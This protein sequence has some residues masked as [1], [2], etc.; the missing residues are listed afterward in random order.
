[1]RVVCEK[2]VG[3][4]CLTSVGLLSSQRLGGMCGVDGGDTQTH[5][6]A[7]LVGTGRGMLAAVL[8]RLLLVC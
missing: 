7:Q 6:Y 4:L 1:M 2:L 5:T 8:P 3:G